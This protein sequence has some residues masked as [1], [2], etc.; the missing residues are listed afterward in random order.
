MMF[1]HGFAALKASFQLLHRTLD[2][3]I[4][5]KVPE[6]RE[7]TRNAHFEAAPFGGNARYLADVVA[8][9]Q[10]RCDAFQRREPASYGTWLAAL[11]GSTIH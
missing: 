10:E 7:A 9:R 11:F 3:G 4:A 6:P 1:P 5:G 2:N 8:T